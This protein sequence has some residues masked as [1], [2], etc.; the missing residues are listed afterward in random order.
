M[1]DF[2]WD[3]PSTWDG[4]QVGKSF[5]PQG[6]CDDKFITDKVTRAT[7]RFRIYSDFNSYTIGQLRCTNKGHLGGAHDVQINNHQQ[8]QNKHNQ[9]FICS[10][11]I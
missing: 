11:V 10:S 7:K 9:H 4:W 1:S 2:I 5:D 6:T 3:W 8:H